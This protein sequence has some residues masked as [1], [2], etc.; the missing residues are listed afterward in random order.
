MAGEREEG[1]RPSQPQGYF[2]PLM[3]EK[4]REVAL[5]NGR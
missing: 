2:G 4:L 3:E 1:A 5:V